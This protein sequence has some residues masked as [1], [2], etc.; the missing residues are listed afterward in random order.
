LVHDWRPST[1]PGQVA[2]IIIWLQQ[3]REG[4][5]TRGEV[6]KVEYHLGPKF[7]DHPPIKTDA[8]DGFRL[9]VSAYAPMLC[10]A[11]VFLRGRSDPVELTRYVD[12]DETPEH[13][14]GG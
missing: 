3:H 11:R 2:D 14:S 12:F 7:F 1:T 6:L 8:S 4:P 10:L 13:P 5:L 9:E